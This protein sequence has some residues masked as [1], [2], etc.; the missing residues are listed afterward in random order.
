MRPKPNGLVKSR[1]LSEW[2]QYQGFRRREVN[3]G[4]R[5]ID[6]PDHVLK[7]AEYLMSVMLSPFG[8]TSD[9]APLPRMIP[10]RTFY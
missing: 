3:T 9:M 1:W 7:C 8:L 10:Q 4:D 5:L 2:R 6:G